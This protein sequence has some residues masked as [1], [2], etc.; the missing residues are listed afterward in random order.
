MH[1]HSF[2]RSY[3]IAGLL[4]LVSAA[5]Q[6]LTL[7]RTRG[8]VLIGQPLA[9]DIALTLDAGETASALCLEADVFHADT[10]VSASKVTAIVVNGNTA[11]DAVLRIRSQSVVDEPFVM[12]FVRAGCNQKITRRYTLLA[13][14][15]GDIAPAGVTLS[16]AIVP[17]VLARQAPSAEKTAQ[18][19]Q[20]PGQNL[21]RSARLAQQRAT[22]ANAKRAAELQIASSSAEA[23]PALPAVASAPALPAPAAPVVAAPVAAAAA[24][25]APAALPEPPS[26]PPAPGSQAVLPTSQARVAVELPATAVTEQL[27]QPAKADKPAKTVVKNNKP[28]KPKSIEKAGPAAPI[29]RLVIDP[30][31]LLA[32]RAPLLKASPE[33]L[34][35]PTE[36]VQQRAASAALWRAL[37]TPPLDLLSD[38]ERVERLEAQ[39]NTVRSQNVQQ[40]QRIGMLNSQ[41]DKARAERYNNPL[42]YALSGTALLLILL[43]GF[44]WW[45]G[46][47]AAASAPAWWLAQKGE[48]QLD[49]EWQYD[50]SSQSQVADPVLDTGLDK[51]PAR[52]SV[53]GK[54]PASAA[55][56]TQAVGTDFEN[57]NISSVDVPHSGQPLSGNADLDLDL[58][59]DLSMPLS[60]V[61]TQPVPTSSKTA[62]KPVA[63]SSA[64]PAAKPSAA[65]PSDFMLS[66]L[67]M[68]RAVNTEELFDVQQQADFFVSLGQFDQAISVLKEHINDNVQTSALAYLDLLN[69]YHNLDR[70]VDYSLLRDEFHKV[71]NAVAPKFEDFGNKTRGLESYFVAM[72]RIQALWPSPKVLD[73]IEESV[74]RKPGEEGDEAFDLE[75]YRDLILL[76]TL[77]KG[78][79]EGGD[80]QAT[81][82][83]LVSRDNA[84]SKPAGPKRSGFASTDIQPLSALINADITKP[85]LEQDPSQPVDML[86]PPAS[87]RLGLDFD[88]SKF[89]PVR[90]SAGSEEAL[91]PATPTPQ[92]Y[93]SSGL[94]EFD[95]SQPQPS[96]VVPE[97]KPGATAKPTP[98]N[99]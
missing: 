13:D 94:M 17:P 79:M 22:A 95:L 28:T 59:L 52:P 60:S 93:P 26:A 7:G 23:R 84:A 1:R 75:A 57:Q 49:G 73:V 96:S 24:A 31:E 63:K 42:I 5:S 65:T 41:L 46:R 92:P 25:P 39:A 70:K 71:F 35:T 88:L 32:E 78:M 54:R 11:Q 2:L 51:R 8:V 98:P 90:T 38:L 72:A 58:D 80:A 67:G 34:S 97:D 40:E 20:K 82:N 50:R 56:H 44:F 18:P 85:R 21:S 3:L 33:M 83:Q 45:R 37:N 6:A 76:H 30:Q 27:V 47:R 91:H 53:P 4:V 12:L 16:P 29:P 99:R 86:R 77:I 9:V 14:V 48:P 43:S 81:S 74:F 87:I 89:D 19:A 61:R 55:A 68:A 69:I 15:A 64:M 36:N 62:L 66:Q 10:Q